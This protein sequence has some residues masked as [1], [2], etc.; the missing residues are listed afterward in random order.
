[1]FKRIIILLVSTLLL[2]CGSTKNQHRQTPHKK[3]R[4]VVHKVQIDYD[5]KGVKFPGW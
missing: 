3:S 2:A 5:R 4:K 1:M